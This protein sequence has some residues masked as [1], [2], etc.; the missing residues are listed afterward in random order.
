MRTI[1]FGAVVAIAVACL[2][3]SGHTAEK[4]KSAAPQT[5]SATGKGKPDC[6]SYVSGLGERSGSKRYKEMIISSRNQGR[7]S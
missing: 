5:T 6:A 7:C 4:K 1:S 3:S 2:I